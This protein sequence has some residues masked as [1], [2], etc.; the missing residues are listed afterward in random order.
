MNRTTSRLW[1]QYSQPTILTSISTFIYS[2]ICKWRVALVWQEMLTRSGAP[3]FIC[4]PFGWRIHFPCPTL[5]WHGMVIHFARKLL[6][7][8]WCCALFRL[9]FLVH[10]FG[11]GGA[12]E[13]CVTFHVVYMLYICYLFCQNMDYGLME[14]DFVCLTSECCLLY[15][16][17]LLFHFTI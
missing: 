13:G 10:M 5:S 4:L 3:D 15:Y 16:C 2:D 11:G 6:A 1:L 14:N 7:P 17:A 12:Q 9:S 8:S